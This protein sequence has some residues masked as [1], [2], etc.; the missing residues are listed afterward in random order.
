MYWS[1]PSLPACG[2]LFLPMFVIFLPW[3]F[4][5]RFAALQCSPLKHALPMAKQSYCQRNF[6]A[7]QWY[8]N[9]FGW[10]SRYW[11]ALLAVF[12]HTET[13]NWKVWTY[14]SFFFFFFLPW[15]VVEPWGYKSFPF[16]LSSLCNAPVDWT[17]FERART[18]LMWAHCLLKSNSVLSLPC[19]GQCE[20]GST[21]VSSQMNLD[22]VQQASHITLGRRNVCLAEGI[23]LQGDHLGGASRMWHRKDL[24]YSLTPTICWMEFSPFVIS[25]SHHAAPGNLGNTEN[26]E[27]SRPRCRH[28]D[29]PQGSCWAQQ[30]LVAAGW[31]AGSIWEQ[32]PAV[33]TRPSYS[34]PCGLQTPEHISWQHNMH[35]PKQ[36][37]PFRCPT[38]V[39]QEEQCQNTGREMIP[40]QTQ[41][42]IEIRRS[43][44]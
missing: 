18:T 8:R 23:T 29:K 11:E 20:T 37:C 30:M 9:T 6:P 40:N 21:C 31:P 41:G 15:E 16:Q 7:V 24:K 25:C 3:H 5:S 34:S 22:N 38:A 42:W 28:W 36:A 32:R 44:Y 10:K 39:G 1:S 13:V 43:K 2:L 26:T 12:N 17:V 35:S 19:Q 33:G 4:T 27:Q 14:V